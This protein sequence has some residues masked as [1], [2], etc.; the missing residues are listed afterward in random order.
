MGLTASLTKWLFYILPAAGVWTVP[1]AV[2]DQGYAKIGVAV[3]ALITAVIA[4]IVIT[5]VAIVVV[6]GALAGDEKRT[7]I[8]FFI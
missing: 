3:I 7:L 4:I 6:I 1:L 2:R 8:S 5:V